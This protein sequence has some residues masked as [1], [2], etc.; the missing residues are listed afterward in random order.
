MFL[1]G[2]G[3]RLSGGLPHAIGTLARSARWPKVIGFVHP[4]NPAHRESDFLVPNFGGFVIVFVDRYGQSIWIDPEPLFIGEQL[5]SPLDGFV[6]K[7]I[8]KAEV[9]EHLEE[10]VVISGSADVIDITGSQALLACRR[11]GEVEFDLTQEMVFELVHPRRR[12]KYRG[13]PGRHQH[14]TGLPMVS[15]GLEEG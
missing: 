3:L 6:F 11:P 4:R 14:I 5:P 8:A 12:K 13:I 2:K 1:L 7:I 10:R 15:L 9:A